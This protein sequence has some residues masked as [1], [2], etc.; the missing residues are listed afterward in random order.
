VSLIP[1]P[2]VSPSVRVRDTFGVRWAP[3]RLRSR[4]RDG[5]CVE[6]PG[7][8]IVTAVAGVHT[9]LD[10][11]ATTGAMLVSPRNAAAQHARAT[12]RA[13]SPNLV[14]VFDRGRT[15]HVA[16]RQA[17]LTRPATSRRASRT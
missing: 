8:S 9:T 13:G 12:I 10:I 5:R 16:A 2:P 17:Q 14:C 3:Y 7:G 4:H 6:P 1:T 11:E 15:P